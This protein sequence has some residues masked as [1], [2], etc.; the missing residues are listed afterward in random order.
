[1]QTASASEPV[2][3]IS[4]LQSP[5][6]LGMITI[7]NRLVA[8][9]M[10]RSAGTSR[11]EL[12]PALVSEYLDLAKGQW[13]IL[14]VEAM[15]TTPEYKS[16]K[17]QLVINEHTKEELHDLLSKM[18]EIAP[19]TKY[20]VQL[21]APGVIAGNG[22]QKTTII[23]AVH[24]ADPTINLFSDDEIEAIIKSYKDAID[25]VVHAGI[26]GIDLK[27][28]HGYLGSEFLRPAN[29]RAGEYGGS[30]E[31]RTRFFKDLFEHAKGTA[32]TVGKEDFLLGSRIS[33]VESIAGG[34]GTSGP[35]EYIEDLAE[36]K[37]FVELLCD[38]GANFINVTAGIPAITPE[39]TRPTKDVPWG[40]WNHFRLTKAIK[41]HLHDKGKQAIVIGSAYTMLGT[42][43]P[44]YAAKN[45][46]AGCVDLIGLG[47]QV[48]A[49]PG[50]PRKLFSG[51]I[52][53][54]KICNGCGG[55]AKLLQQQRHVGC[56]YHDIKFKIPIRA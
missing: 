23:P 20:I 55:C 6:E 54:I 9:P 40:I 16:R 21:T 43:L 39:L 22:L 12:T 5:I 4:T 36:P 25:L 13:G 32:E 51:K 48:L 41:D 11:G 2:G 1:M 53:D 24:D 27:A 18:R 38:W 42:D 17:N 46:D 7:P 3:S 34:F 15:S 49:D 31:N 50:Y 37:Q 8:Q 29:T 45:I 56:V 26:D 52:N 44:R 30:F 14:H 47:R 10:E 19:E 28:C 33:I 35:D